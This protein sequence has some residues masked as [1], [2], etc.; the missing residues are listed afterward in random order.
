[1]L[2][3]ATAG[4]QAVQCSGQAGIY[5]LH[6]SRVE[7]FNTLNLYKTPCTR[8]NPERTPSPHA[9]RDISPH[10]MCLRSRVTSRRG[11]G[12][13]MGECVHTAQESRHQA[14]F[15][16][17]ID[18]QT[19]VHEDFTIFAQVSQFYIYSSTYTTYC[20]QLFRCRLSIGLNVLNVKQ[21]VGAFNPEKALVA[22]RGL[23]CDCEIFVRCEL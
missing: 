10:S 8:Q 19:K 3:G 18:L 5:N 9:R 16:K 12:T 17:R 20:V 6:R 2:G 22:R 7:V 23:L 15:Y 14:N 11:H 1:M 13:G 4:M 21:L